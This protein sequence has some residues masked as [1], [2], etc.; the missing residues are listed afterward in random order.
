VGVVVGERGVGVAVGLAVAVG[1]GVLVAVGVG[2]VVGRGGVAVSVG[3]AIGFVVEVAGTSAWQAMKSKVQITR[4][5]P[6]KVF[7]IEPLDLK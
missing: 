1:L 2:E 5:G 4:M 6:D 3:V 7:K